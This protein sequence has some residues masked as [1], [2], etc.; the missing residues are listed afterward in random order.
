MMGTTVLD[1][2]VPAKAG[3]HVYA[4]CEREPHGGITLLV[5]N[6]SHDTWHA[7]TLPDA[8]ER[9]TLDAT[10]LQDGTVRLNG[11]PLKLNAQD[12]LPAVTGVRMAAGTLTFAPATITFLS[13]PAAG[14]GACR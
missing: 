1:P 7:L 13:I 3:L 4:H 11:R 6:A 5:I 9:F 12:D 2:G 8:S 10:K 14:N